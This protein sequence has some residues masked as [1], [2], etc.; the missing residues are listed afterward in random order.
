MDIA[1]TTHECNSVHDSSPVDTGGI[2]QIQIDAADPW[3]ALDL[4]I[5]SDDPRVLAS[6][7]IDH[8]LSAMFPRHIVEIL[9]D[10]SQIEDVAEIPKHSERLTS[11]LVDLLYAVNDAEE[12]TH[13]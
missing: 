8:P 9:A 5:E 6:G 1:D 10:I 3:P 13:V 7:L 2:Q 12:A 11:T 4:A